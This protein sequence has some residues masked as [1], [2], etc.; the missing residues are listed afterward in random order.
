MELGIAPWNLF[1]LIKARLSILNF[2]KFLGIVPLIRLFLRS[3]CINEDKFVKDLGN[4]P[5]IILS[6]TFRTVSDLLNRPMSI[7]SSPESLFPIKSMIRRKG[8]DVM[9]EGIVPVMPF[10]SAMVKLESLSN[11]HISGEIVPVM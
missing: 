11:L 7:G 3:K 9:Q 2:P 4:L 8:K 5:E 6:A 1:L 10:Q